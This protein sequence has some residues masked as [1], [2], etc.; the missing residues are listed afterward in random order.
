MK[1]KNSPRAS[2]SYLLQKIKFGIKN[3]KKN[4]YTKRKIITF[5]SRI[6]KRRIFKK[7][8]ICLPKTPLK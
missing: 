3:E 6:E 4:V 5:Y 7:K 2:Y 8:N 1:S